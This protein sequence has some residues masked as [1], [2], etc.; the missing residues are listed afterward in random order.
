MSRVKLFA[1]GAVLLA[2]AIGT[3]AGILHSQNAERASGSEATE[4]EKALAIQVKTVHPRKGAVA[5]LCV[6][7]GSVDSFKHIDVYAQVPGYL[8]IQKVDIG[9]H[10]KKG[11]IL[12]IV[13]VPDIEARVERNVAAVAKTKAQLEQMK[14]RLDVA[15]ANLDAANAAVA[16]AEANLKSATAW[17]TY[18]K[19]QLGRI[20]EL[21]QRKSLQDQLLDETKERHEAAVETEVAAK[22]AIVTS[23]AKVVACK[24][25][26]EQAKSDIVE[27]NA[28]IKVAEAELKKSRVDLDFATIRAEFDGVVTVR[29]MNTGDFVRAANAGGSV[30]LFTIARTD[31]FRVVVLVPD[32]DV[33][34]CQVGK[35]ATMEIDSLPGRKFTATVSRIAESLDTNTRLM[36]VELDLPNPTGKIYHGM[37]GQV[38][39]ALQNEADTLSIPYSCLHGKPD[40]NKATIYVVRGG[41]AKRLEVELG[42]DTGVRVSVPSGLSADDQVILNPS[43]ALS[44][45]PPVTA[46]LTKD[47]TVP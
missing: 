19:L 23:N 13:D 28:E 33:E 15:K 27:A 45:E 41:K 44:E 36:R 8:K 35:Q 5:R 38:S 42:I 6:Q 26:I 10:V 17:V 22:A 11:D 47:P 14:S 32:R 25:K 39:I 18:R 31:K 21:V 40:H 9:D 43:S 37:Y 4:H 7:P 29:N 46:I 2:V 3:T 16:Q 34:F 24:A 12:A 30:P 20:D 1:G